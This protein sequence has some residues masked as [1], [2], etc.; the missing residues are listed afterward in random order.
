MSDVAWAPDGSSRWCSARACPTATSR[1]R[2][3]STST[4]RNAD[5]SGAAKNLTAVQQGVGRRPGVQRRRQDAVLPRDEAA[6]LRGRSLRADGDGPRPRARRTRSIRN[7]IARPNGI[8]LSADGKTI[9]TTAENI[10]QQPLF[11]VDIA[12]GGVTELIG[13]GTVSAF[14]IAGPTLVFARN[15]MQTGDQ[16]FTGGLNGAPVAPRSPRAR[17]RCCRT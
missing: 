11:A 13:D 10:G 6:G 2:P 14:V 3:I 1:I 15:S 5:G 12:S 8:T 9:Y 7:G 16:L 17:A 4:A